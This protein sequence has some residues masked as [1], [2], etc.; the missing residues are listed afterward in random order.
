MQPGLE[1]RLRLRAGAQLCGHLVGVVLVEHAALEPSGALTDGGPRFGR[2][3]E[4]PVE[5]LQEPG[6]RPH[7]ALQRVLLAPAQELLHPPCA[8]RRALGRLANLRHLGGPHARAVRR[9]G[10]LQGLA[11]RLER[12]G[13]P[14]QPRA[15]G[16]IAHAVAACRSLVGER[17]ERGAAPLELPRQLGAANRQRLGADA[18]PLVSGSQGRQPAPDFGSL[19]IAMGEPLLD[20]GA[21]AVDLRLLGLDALA[22]LPGLCRVALGALELARVQAELV[23]QQARAQL[24]GLPLEAG[25]DVRRLRLALQRAQPAARLALHVE[26]PVEVVL[27]ALELQLRPP[28]ALAMLA[29]PG[30]LLDQKPPIAGLRVDYLL[31][32]AL[33]DHRVHLASEVRVSEDLDHIDK[34]AA[35]AVQPVLALAAALHPAPDRDLRELAPRRLAIRVVQHHLDLGIAAGRL[36]LA[37]SE[38]H[39]LHGLAAD[40]E[41]ALLPEGPEH[42]VGDVRLAAA[43]RADDHADAGREHEPSALRE[44]L[45][46]LDRDRAQVHGIG[47]AAPDRLAVGS[48]GLLFRRLGP[49][50]YRP[51]RSSASAAAACSAA[52]LLRPSPLPISS[53]SLSAATS[54]LRSWGGPVSWTTS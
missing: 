36:R 48:D 3:L 21:A 9:P 47:C 27:G 52:F 23:R 14:P 40:R 19:A 4:Q 12:R 39:V 30:R 26:R 1:L 41:R 18:E 25:L 49:A 32:P 53:A 51:R 44:G 16:V 29:E 43:V 5:P 38:D 45:E 10:A 33:A 7:A 13:D 22:R 31:H 50:S 8:V 11:R 2:R 42:R 37:A 54:K 46:A 17:A 6:R 20:L 15:H 28:A 35:R 24:P 34:P